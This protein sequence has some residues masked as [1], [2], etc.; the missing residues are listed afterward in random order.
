MLVHVYVLAFIYFTLSPGAD[1]HRCND[2]PSTTQHLPC[3]LN[4][5]AQGT[6][7]GMTLVVSVIFISK[8]TFRYHNFSEKVIVNKSMS[9]KIF[10]KLGTVFS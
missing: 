2:G 3:F 7:F 6:S 10:K 4:N 5:I 9:S 8:L 1:C